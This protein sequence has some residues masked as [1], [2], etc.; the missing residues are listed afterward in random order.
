MIL[1]LDASALVK[2]YVEEPGS[3]EIS[4]AIERA[5]AVG[6]VVIIYRPSWRPYPGYDER[7]CS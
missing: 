4:S 3:A 2:R 1:Y 7:E 6:T 5:I